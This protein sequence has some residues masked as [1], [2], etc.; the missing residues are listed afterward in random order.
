MLFRSHSETN[1]NW[2]RLFLLIVTGEQVWKY[3]QLR[4]QIG[5]YA[6][7]FPYALRIIGKKD[8]YIGKVVDIRWNSEAIDQDDI[9]GIQPRYLIARETVAG[10]TEIRWICAYL[11]NCAT[12]P[13]KRYVPSPF[14]EITTEDIASR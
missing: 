6:Y 2:S 10:T 9:R 13:P 3:I 7:S 11:V 1:W 14:P 5:Q 12:Q 8:Q 4:H